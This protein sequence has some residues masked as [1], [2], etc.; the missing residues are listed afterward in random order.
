MTPA[1]VAP[2]C[3]PEAEPAKFSLP[4]WIA[5]ALA[6]AYL[7]W[8]LAHFH[9][10]IMS[11]DANGY[12]VQGRLLA[13]EGQTFFSTQSPAQ[14]VGMHWLETT[15]GIFH[16]RYPAGLPAVF[17]LAWKF[18][19][20]RAALLVNPLLS[21]GT[22]LLVFCLARRFTDDWSALLAA[23]V[24]ATNS[25]V[26]Q[27]ALD[28]DSHTAA[29]FFLLA[30][31][32]ALW[33]FAEAPATWRG[34]LAGLLLG[35]VPTVRYPEAIAGVAVASWMVSRSGGSP[36]ASLKAAGSR[37]YPVIA[38]AALP[39]AALLLHNAVAYGAVWRTGYALTGEQT[40]FGWNYFSAHVFSYMQSLSGDG[41]TLFF[42]FGAAGLAGLIA[43]GSHR[44]DGLL[45]AGIAV[46]LLLLYM[47]YYFGGGDSGLRF[48]V[49]TFPF[50]A[51]AG[52]WLLGRIRVALG[53]S[54]W[55]VW[56]TVASLQLTT[57]GAA[58]VQTTAREGAS[59]LAAA[60]IEQLVQAKAPAGSV[61]IAGPG[62]VD[63]LDALGQ[64]HLVE[65]NLVT[66]DR[67]GFPG[68]G[69]FGR[70]PVGRAG[71]GRGVGLGLAGAAGG[72]R[73]GG[74]GQPSPQQANKNQAQ[75]ARYDNLSAEDRRAR[76]WEDI[77]TWAAGRSV[78]WL[79]NSLDAVEAELPEGADYT[80]VGK[81]DAP[82]MGMM[83]PGGGRP[84][85]PGGGGFMGPGMGPGG[86]APGLGRA[87]A[88]GGAQTQ[89]LQ[90]V[91]IDFGSSKSS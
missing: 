27:H 7:G 32:L 51:A 18:G 4:Q 54:G 37:F 33:R 67:A 57:A 48:F 25:T 22:V 68:G 88:A 66:G 72:P 85:M 63:S 13:T 59:L 55:A 5:A 78:Y 10:A 20:L 40:G 60:R 12:V 70:R 91:R 83:G 38:G 53:P 87:G 90:L 1:A 28:A 35:M 24:M 34:L 9:P 58:A 86:A 62:V 8:I 69:Q 11:P 43:D 36:L 17:A 19:G 79:A 29:T 6:L 46:P 49:P 41:L 84:G 45:L 75:R 76:V 82:A 44:A 80:A 61:L 56:A 15:R 39:I 2:A 14:Y 50:F 31:I 30:G 3:V 47:A 81:I 73:A 89:T 42:A 52:A 71:A 65:A 26:Q 64:W 74:A 16:S 21:S 23:A 77:R